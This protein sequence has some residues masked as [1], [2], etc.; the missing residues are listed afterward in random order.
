MATLVSVNVGTPRTFELKGKTHTSSI[1]K[2]PFPGRVAVRGVNVEGDEQ[3]DRKVHGGPDKAVY[4]YA[5]EDY[6]WWSDQL[7]TELG[8]G[9]FGENLTTSGIDLNQALVGE[10]WQVGTAILEVAQP[11]LPCFKLGFRMEDPG[12]PRKFS[13]ARRWGAYLRIIEAG[14]VGAGDAIDVLERPDHEVTV[15]LIASTYYGDHSRAGEILAAP[16][17]PRGWRDWAQKAL[18]RGTEPELAG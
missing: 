1:W 16:K 17:L 10:R 12:F 13:D 8:P 5:A 14:E 7:G 18:S 4:S 11:R 6:E 9:T 3:S 15:D 2:H